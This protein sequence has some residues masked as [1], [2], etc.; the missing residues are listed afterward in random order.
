MREERFKY[1]K[2]ANCMIAPSRWPEPFGIVALEA[3]AYELPLIVL[4]KSAGLVE[5]VTR[6]DVGIVSKEED[7]GRNVL[8][9]MKNLKRFRKNCKKGIK[10]YDKGHIFKKYRKLFEKEAK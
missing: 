1:F 9:L 3:M 6:N 4:D 5:T 2:K 7:I 10:K 8:E